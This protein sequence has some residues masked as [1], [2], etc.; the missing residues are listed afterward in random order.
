MAESSVD[1]F[2]RLVQVRPPE[3]TPVLFDTGCV[4]G[5]SIAGLLAARV[6]AGHSRRVLIIERDRPDPQGLPR[7]GVPQDRQ[8][9]V[10]YRSVSAAADRVSRQVRVCPSV[11]WSATGVTLTIGLG[12]SSCTV[13][14]P[15]EAPT[16]ASPW[17]TRRTTPYRHH[18][19]GA[20]PGGGVG[21]EEPDLT[22]AMAGDP[23]R[24]HPIGLD[25]GVAHL[26]RGGQF[27]ALHLLQASGSS[28]QLPLIFPFGQ[29]TVRRSKSMAAKPKCPATYATASRRSGSSC[30][31]RGAR[32][33]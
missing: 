9:A 4:L 27:Q 13:R 8:R 11:T 6:L 19:G 17:Q 16:T 31:C 5:G 7:G 18:T 24:H 30:R 28:S 20:L 15:A 32:S 21:G 23:Y 33:R 2:D 26:L 1:V 22:A 14:P 10:G 25:P 3:H 29:V 12:S